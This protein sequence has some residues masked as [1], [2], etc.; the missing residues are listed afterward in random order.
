MMPNLFGQLKQ[1]RKHFRTAA[2]DP[3]RFRPELQQLEARSVPSGKAVLALWSQ[4]AYGTN[5]YGPT[6]VTY[7]VSEFNP[8]TG[9]EQVLFQAAIPNSGNPYHPFV[10]PT[11]LA[12]AGGDLFTV[13]A[14][15]AGMG[16]VDGNNSLGGLTQGSSTIQKNA[17]PGG[18]ARTFPTAPPPDPSPP[19]RPPVGG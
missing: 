1:L 5:S 6:A 2:P 4:G 18:A 10:F 3:Q 14:D 19:H 9:S 7:G 17:P 8:A 16:T 11:S 15:Q 12:Q 13:S